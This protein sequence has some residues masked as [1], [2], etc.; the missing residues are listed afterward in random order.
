[1]DDGAVNALKSGK[2]LLPIGVIAV[3]GEFERGAAVA[4]IAPTGEEIARGLCNYGSG[5]ARLIAR[6]PTGEIEA[7]LGYIEEPEIIHR[8]NLILG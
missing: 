3:S 1:L 2:S 5:E 4:C 8:D 7:T 6:K